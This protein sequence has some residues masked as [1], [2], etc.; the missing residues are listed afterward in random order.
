MNKG[1]RKQDRLSNKICIPKKKKFVNIHEHI[2]I[3][4]RFI[5]LESDFI[6]KRDVDNE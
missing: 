3:E 1:N 5:K 6:W 2:G 4:K